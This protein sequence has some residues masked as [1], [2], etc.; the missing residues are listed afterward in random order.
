MASTCEVNCNILVLGA[1]IV[2]LNTALRLQTDFPKGQITIMAADWGENTVSRVA[3]GFFRATKSIRGP[4]KEIAQ[5]WTR[6]S[7]G[8]Y[9]H[10]K[11]TE[12]PRDTGI[13]DVSEIIRHWII[14]SASSLFLGSHLRHR[15]PW[16]SRPGYFTHGGTLSDGARLHQTRVGLV[17]AER[18]I[19]SRALF[20]INY[21]QS[22]GILIENVIVKILRVF[23][24][25]DSVLYAMGGE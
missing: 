13:I 6:E 9:Q 14:Q 7:W 3:A 20:Q 2:G 16:G 5:Q 17:C 22:W 4:T 15:F 8:F 23:F 12:S 24:I 21:H 11:V 18:K 1:G 19:H 25:L 10:L